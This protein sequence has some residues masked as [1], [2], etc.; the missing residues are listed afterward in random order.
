M[1]VGGCLSH[2]RVWLRLPYMLHI[3]TFGSPHGNIPLHIY[4]H[5]C[6]YLIAKEHDGA[7][8]SG[9]E[10]PRLCR[11]ER[12]VQ[13]SF[14]VM[15]RMRAENLK[16]NYERIFVQIRVNFSVQDVH[17]CVVRCRSK[18]RIFFMKRDAL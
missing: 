12:T 11:M 13:H 9:A 3:N 1:R 2:F 15:G 5:T 18:Q 6:L 8:C 10:K 4:A 7:I 16:R 17:S 14:T